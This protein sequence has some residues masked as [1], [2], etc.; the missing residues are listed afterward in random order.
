MKSLRYFVFLS[1]PLLIG[2]FFI[3]HNSKTANSSQTKEAVDRDY[4]K[5]EIVVELKDSNL[6][7]QKII[8]SKNKYRT[9][10]KK[11]SI[12][13][14]ESSTSKKSRSNTYVVKTKTD[15][16][17][18]AKLL[19]DD[20]RVKYAEPNYILSTSATP[21]DTTY[22]DQWHLPKIDAPAA[23]NITQGSTNVVIAVVD[24]GVDWDH[25]DLAG[26]IWSNSDE[27]ADGTDSDSNGYIDDVR[28]WDFVTQTSCLAGDDC[29]GSTDNNPMDYHGHGTQ[30]AGTASAVTNNATGVAGVGWKIKI[31]PLRAGYARAGDGKGELLVSDAANAIRYAIDN[32]AD[33]INMSW[34]GEYSSAVKSAK[35]Y[36]YNHG[37]LLV[38]A[39]GNSNSDDP[40]YPAGLDSVLSVGATNSADN[41][42]SSS[43]YGYTVN[44]AAP[45]KNIRT[46]KFNDTYGTSSGTSLATP[47]VSGVAGLIKSKYGVGRKRIVER[48]L[49]GAEDISD[50]SIGDRVNAREALRNLKS[51][52][53]GTLIRQKNK[54]SVYLIKGGKR[55]GIRTAKMFKSQFR[56]KDVVNVTKNQRLAY[57]WGGY[58]G[59]KDGTLVSPKGSGSVFIIEDG[60]RRPFPS[61]ST[62]DYYGYKWNRIKQEKNSALKKAHPRGDKVTKSES[63]P[64]GSLVR[65][66]GKGTVFA[67]RD[68][69]R[70]PITSPSAFKSRKYRWGDIIDTSKSRVNSINKG[71]LL[72]HEDGTLLREKGSG[73]VYYLQANILRKFT[74]ANQFENMGYNWNRVYDIPSETINKY[75]EDLLPSM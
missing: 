45:G 31:M 38:A 29:D 14:I 57:D 52:P 60:L 40:I 4:K 34:G 7:P 21:N 46:T 6:D 71:D 9:K 64:N 44:I 54:S 48:L 17:S 55:W 15:S 70:C 18:A 23:W 24:T 47:I 43:N 63:F 3:T 66:N 12:S 59:F 62:F 1:L 61:A 2:A 53:N 72:L 56:W 50:K 25:P 11:Q 36:A 33:I 13:S 39:A 20:P 26:N 16:K 37:A 65:R 42:W 28:G 19:E 49:N 67:I 74:S 8:R 30:V 27:V 35:D 73:T 75:K 51:H 41:R 10:L 22:S 68:N 58:L 32:G 69:K 5:D